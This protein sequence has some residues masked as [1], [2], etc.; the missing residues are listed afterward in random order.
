MKAATSYED[1]RERLASLAET[2]NPAKFEEQLSQALGV[3]YM[4]GRFTEAGGGD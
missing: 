1:L 3:A 2:M 4:A